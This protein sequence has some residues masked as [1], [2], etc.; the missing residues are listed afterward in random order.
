MGRNIGLVPQALTTRRLAG[1]WSS[2]VSFACPGIPPHRDVDLDAL[3]A[4]NLTGSC[5]KHAVN[6]AGSGL[7]GK[8]KTV[9]RLVEF[10]RRARARYP[11]SVRYLAAFEHEG[12]RDLVV[13]ALFLCREADHD[14]ADQED[15]TGK[16]FGE[17]ATGGAEKRDPVAIHVSD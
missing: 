5:I 7:A 3:I 13:Q 12:A 2:V 11:D 14:E 9:F 4:S 16:D 10:G 15:E 8:A 1:A 6:V 17:V